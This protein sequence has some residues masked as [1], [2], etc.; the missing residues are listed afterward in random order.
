MQKI[1]VG[2]AS[3]S[4]DENVCF[5]NFL[6]VFENG[7][8]VQHVAHIKLDVA[9]CFGHFLKKGSFYSYVIKILT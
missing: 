3:V 7:G 6:N 9:H 4:R 8:Q 1:S 2:S 5:L